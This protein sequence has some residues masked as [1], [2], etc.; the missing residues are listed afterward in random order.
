MRA[1][2]NKEQLW[3]SRVESQQSS[4]LSIKLWCEREKIS[5][6][7][8]YGWRKRVLSEGENVP[9]LIKVSMAGQENERG[10][11]ILT[12]LGYVIRLSSVTQVSHLRAI[13]SSLS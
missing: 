7:K 10:L 11:E 2:E 9:N 3:R 4:G 5:R 13:V 12:P 8:F 6:S 1:S